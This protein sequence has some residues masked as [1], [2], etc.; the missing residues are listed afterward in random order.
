MARLLIALFF[1]FWI[2]P[3]NLFGGTI[4]PNTPDSNYVE[5]GK[6]FHYI[7]KICGEYQDGKKYCASAVA[8]SPRWVITAAHV[9]KNSKSSL[10]KIDEKIIQLEKVICHEDFEENK[11]GHYDL[12]ICKSEREI[13]LNFYPDIYD[14]NDEVGQICSIS[15][16]GLTGNFHT[17]AIKD[18][19]KR[20]SGSNRVDYVDRHLLVCSPSV[21]NKT[22]LE[23][24]ICS[25]DSGG[26]LFLGNKLAG[27]N[28]CVMAV[29]KTPNSN[30]T[31]ESG[32]TRLS[33]FKNWIKEKIK[34]E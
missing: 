16:W 13:G 33:L 12:A 34:N 24:L 1:C 10:I 15:G 19:G 32:H 27:I 28:S 3:N 17:G 7:L 14:N 20:R 4:D 31:D 23:F 25:G 5:Y 21:S 2:Q 8:I 9:V 6:K 22:S 30:Y 11:F 29:D 26:G 18:D